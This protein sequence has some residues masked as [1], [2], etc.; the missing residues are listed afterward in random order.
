MGSVCPSQRVHRRETERAR[1]EE[2]VREKKRIHPR[3]CSIFNDGNTDISDTG[4]NIKQTAPLLSAQKEEV[5]EV[6]EA[7]HAAASFLAC[8]V[9]VFPVL[10]AAF[11]VVA[12]PVVASPVAAFPVAASPV[13]AFH[14]AAFPVVAFRVAAFLAAAFLAG[15]PYQVAALKHPTA[16]Q[17]TKRNYLLHVTR[18]G[19][20]SCTSQVPMQKHWSSR[21]YLDWRIEVITHPHLAWMCMRIR[22]VLGVLSHRLVAHRM[23]VA[24]LML[25]AHR[26]LLTNRMLLAHRLLLLLLL[27]CVCVCGARGKRQPPRV[28]RSQPEFYG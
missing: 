27:L 4:L 20:T 24:H 6:V 1:K 18:D 17:H 7:P 8:Q 15:H 3:L 25:L 14:F 2:R 28:T 16:A 11:P 23:L 5:Q 10:V 12:F 26:R 21:H 19:H 9:G 22:I 13:A